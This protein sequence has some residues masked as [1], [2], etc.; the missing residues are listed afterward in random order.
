MI[1][2]SITSTIHAMGQEAFSIGSARRLVDQYGSG[3]TQYALKRLK[4]KKH[5]TNPTW[6]RDLI[7]DTGKFLW[8]P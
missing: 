4:T 8:N 2:K 6:L 1:A 7:T 3:A 5:V